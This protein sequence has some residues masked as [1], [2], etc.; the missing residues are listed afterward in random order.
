[1]RFSRK[2]KKKLK[3]ISC[4]CYESGIRYML[5]YRVYNGKTHCLVCGGKEVTKYSMRNKK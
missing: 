1:M 3:P 5:W 2:L 4:T